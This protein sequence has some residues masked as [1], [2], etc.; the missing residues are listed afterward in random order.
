MFSDACSSSIYA[1]FGGSKV[2]SASTVVHNWTDPW[3][4]G[5]LYAL[6]RAVYSCREYSGDQQEE[7]P[8]GPLIPLRCDA[9]SYF[10]F[11]QHFSFRNLVMEVA[12]L[13]S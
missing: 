11:V 1:F 3:L 6:F 4:S 10:V 7:N 8:R 13:V 12:S 5:S 9:H 2:F